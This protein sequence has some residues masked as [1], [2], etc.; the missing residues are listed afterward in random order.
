MSCPAIQ[1]GDQF[2]SSSLTALDCNGR[3]LGEAGY[4]ALSAPGSVIQTLLLAMLTLFI[5]I[6]GVKLMF[7]RS[8]DLGDASLAA[9]K[10]G[11][12]LMLATSWPA[13]RTLF[14]DTAIRGPSELVQQMGGDPQGFDSRLQQVDS[15][16]VALTAWGT[17]KL[18][19]RAGRTADGQPAASSFN[20][21]A[22]NE[23]LGFSLGRFLWLGSALGTIG[24]FRLAAGLLV[25]L[26]PLFAGF[27][28]FERTRGLALGWAK[29][30]FFL[31]VAT[32]SASILLTIE[33]SMMEPW[34]ARLIAERAANYA[35]PS[36]PTELLALSG[37]FCLILLGTSLLLARICF[38]ID[39]TPLIASA[40]E[41]SRRGQT[42]HE[43]GPTARADLQTSYLM[44]GERTL[45]MSQA[46][47]RLDRRSIAIS[48]MATTA[49]VGGSS[50][51][52]GQPSAYHRTNGRNRARQRPSL[53][54][55]KRDRQ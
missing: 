40:R 14:Y 25:S 41:W 38:A 12:V 52:S 55:R 9:V 34:L 17:G 51:G 27:L 49:S 45:V 28:L 50:S 44:I 42:R 48:A 26:L 23:G 4:Q 11:L 24:L 7:G 54:S 6:Q 15:G 31:I 37:A 29:G 18:D 46:L 10:I 19:I 43:A 33:A 21:Q 3:W 36:A 2:L 53:S 22:T 1:S 47:D 16:I 35:T 13:V 30:W 39:P 20:G 8:L 32:L 5:V